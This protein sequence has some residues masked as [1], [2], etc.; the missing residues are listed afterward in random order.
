MY[1]PESA[2]YVKYFCND[3]YFYTPH[4]LPKKKH[5]QYSI[6]C[7]RF[8]DDGKHNNLNAISVPYSN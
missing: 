2:H 4:E 1:V 7:V 5:I 8:E 3:C 6:E